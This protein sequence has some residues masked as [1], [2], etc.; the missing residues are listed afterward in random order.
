MAR[1]E[2]IGSPRKNLVFETSG[3]IRVKRGDVYYKLNFE[4]SEISSDEEHESLNSKIIIV[5]SLVQYESGELEYPGDGKIIFSYADGIFYTLDGA[6]NSFMSE[7]E[8][9]AT[10]SSNGII[11]DKT[12]VLKGEPPIMVN[13]NTMIS[14]LNA[15]YLNGHTWDDVQSMI[16]EQSSSLSHKCY[17]SIETCDGAFSVS[18]GVVNADYINCEVITTDT[19][20]FNHLGDSIKL[21]GNMNV[22]SVELYNNYH[23]NPSGVNLIEFL[24]RLYSTRGVD[25]NGSF[26]DWAKQYIAPSN[27]S[28]SWSTPY[29]YSTHPNDFN[30]QLLD[31][32][33]VWKLLDGSE[34]LWKSTACVPIRSTKASYTTSSVDL[35]EEEDL[36]EDPKCSNMTRSSNLY[37]ELQSCI[38]TLIV[39]PEKEI[40]EVSEFPGPVVEILLNG[41]FVIP[42]SRGTIKIGIDTGAEED[43]ES[44]N[45][46]SSY[47]EST[48]K[49]I[50]T[51]V[52]GDS[53][54]IKLDGSIPNFDST[55][56]SKTINFTE[57]VESEGDSGSE[58]DE[59]VFTSVTASCYESNTE[60]TL[61]ADTEGVA[62]A[63]SNLTVIGDLSA[64]TNEVL[65]VSGVGIYSDNIYLYNPEIAYARNMLLPEATEETLVQFIKL[66]D[67]KPF[68]GLCNLEP[69][70]EHPEVKHFIDINDKG[71]GSIH[72]KFFE[73]NDDDSGRIGNETEFISWDDTGAITFSEALI[74]K[75]NLTPTPEPEPS[76]GA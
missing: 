75:L 57:W 67:D 51:G 26:V 8:S 33:L 10:S 1:E 5:P 55:S 35:D 59:T 9:V 72:S 47:S 63:A 42:G 60:V 58:T 54:F 16:E 50:V 68:I 14:N 12:I 17:E 21:E 48:Y 39:D 13:S 73:L 70:E 66:T 76:P 52:L 32:N 49:F 45:E 4:D 6:Y 69:T 15:Q 53:A 7:P 3:D 2:R 44:E 37:N 65:E 64:V 19:V 20:S 36:E 38:H 11:F 29:S 23:I 22:D 41:G 34:V 46:D 25:A 62:F 40:D 71:I 18:G 24:F 61:S 31:D 30:V 28:Y 27:F 43:T 56:T 74:T